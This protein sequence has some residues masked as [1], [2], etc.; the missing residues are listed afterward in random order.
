MFTIIIILFI[1]LLLFYVI[2]L[3]LC[4]CLTWCSRDILQSV[5]DTDLSDECFSF[6][7]HKV[8]IF[9]PRALFIANFHEK[10][11]FDAKLSAAVIL[12]SDLSALIRL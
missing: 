2:L 5:I 3:F 4:A 12:R 7:T 8:R 10:V 9:Y 11:L 6:S 1:G